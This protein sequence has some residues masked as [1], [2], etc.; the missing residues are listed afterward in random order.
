L[1]EGLIRPSALVL[2][3]NEPRAYRETIALALKA[4]RPEAEVIAIEPAELDAEARRRRPDV[5]VCSQ[6]SETVEDVVPS[7]VLLYPDGANMTIVSVAGERSVSGNL[8]L[9][10]LAA[11]VGSA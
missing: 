4:L 9:D 10:D 11:L 2:V 6:M 1:D 7:W 8:V 5:A 3:A